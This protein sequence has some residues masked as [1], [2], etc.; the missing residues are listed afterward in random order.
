MNFTAANGSFATP[1]PTFVKDCESIHPTAKNLAFAIVL[2]VICVFTFVGN[3]CVILTVA[4]HRSLHSVSYVLLVSLALADLFVSMF[5]MPWRIHATIHNTLWCLDLPTCAFWIWTDSF[6]CCASITNLSAVG[7][8]RF[9]AI[10]APLRYNTIMNKKTGSIMV[11]F[12]W[13]YALIWASLGNLNWSNP[14]QEVFDIKISCAKRDTIYYTVVAVFAF[15]V[16]LAVV[17]VSYTYLTRVAIIHVTALQ[18]FMTPQRRPRGCSFQSERTI[19]L[20]KEIKAT[21]MM[22]IVVGVFFIS[23]FPFFV[24]VLKNLWSPAPT[25]PL[26]AELTSV[27]FVFILPNLNSALNPIIY[28]TFTRELRYAFYGFFKKIRQQKRNENSSFTS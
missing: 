25:D 22:V 6:A 13:S 26:L 1:F 21:K 16:P 27:V 9:V 7:I 15:Y 10:K 3:A 23:W 28:M 19:R 11:A 24:M 14:D 20:I 8:E 12:V 17:I 4:C 18:E 5:S 2:T